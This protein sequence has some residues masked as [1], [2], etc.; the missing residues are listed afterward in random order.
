MHP[1]ADCCQPQRRRI[2]VFYLCL[3]SA[4]MDSVRIEA[5]QRG[6][7]HQVDNGVALHRCTRLV[8]D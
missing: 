1:P 3:A 5:A 6:R 7:A 4:S 2:L 8:A